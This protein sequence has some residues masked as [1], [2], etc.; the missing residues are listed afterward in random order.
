ME[1]LS[2]IS[3]P[4]VDKSFLFTSLPDMV[5]TESFQCTYLW[6]NGNYGDQMNVIYVKHNYER[7]FL[8]GGGG[9]VIIGDSGTAFRDGT[10][11][12]RAKPFVTCKLA[13]VPI[14][15]VICSS[16]PER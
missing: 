5:K 13:P 2:N 11:K 15:P 8:G 14:L 6:R 3:Q 4:A 7:F 12:S 1:W 9:E 10:K 16:R